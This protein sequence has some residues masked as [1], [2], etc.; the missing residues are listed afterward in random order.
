MRQMDASFPLRGKI[1]GAYITSALAKTEAVRRGFDDAILMNAHRK[2]SEGSAMNLFLVRNGIIRT[3][4]IT[5][6]ILEGITR[7]SVI[8]IARSLGYTVEESVIDK[9]ELVIAEEVFFS[10]TAVKMTPVNQI[11]HY[12]LPTSR[13]IFDA[14]R[15]K[16]ESIVRGEDQE[17][18]HWIERIQL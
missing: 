13:P 3:P 1:S 17:F 9:S 14:I 2:V 8:G 7:D 11:E 10:G 5:E 16:L 18:S 15:E 6:D 4:A 12:T